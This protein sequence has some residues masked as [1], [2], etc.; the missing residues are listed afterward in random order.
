MK[1]NI[2]ANIYVGSKWLHSLDVETFDINDH[3]I[4]TIHTK[5]NTEVVTHMNNVILT[6]NLTLKT[7][8]NQ[9]N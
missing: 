6:K 7:T 9:K 8:D 1:Q 4:I 3:N 5:E 2:T